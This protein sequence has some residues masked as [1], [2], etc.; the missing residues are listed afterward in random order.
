[1]NEIL[2]STSTYFLPVLLFSKI[3][4]NFLFSAK[5][6]NPCQCYEE[7]ESMTKLTNHLENCIEDYKRI[8]NTQPVLLFEHAVDHRNNFF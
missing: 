4:I 2:Y 7:I 8:S 5:F 1:M 3:F 6:L